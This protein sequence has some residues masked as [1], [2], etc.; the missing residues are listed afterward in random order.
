M[1]SL[2]FVARLSSALKTG[3]THMIER[4]V[5]LHQILAD[6]SNDKFLSKNLLFKG[7]NMLDK[8]PPRIL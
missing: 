8:A 3:K 2:D 6:L 5:I 4:D 1:I 7:R